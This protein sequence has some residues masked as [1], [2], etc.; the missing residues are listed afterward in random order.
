MR[1]E[2]INT[3]DIIYYKLRPSDRPINPDQE[4]K[5]LVKRKHRVEPDIWMLFVQ[6]LGEGYYED[7]TEWIYLAQVTRADKINREK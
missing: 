6:A 5:G 1:Q 2:E 3:G 4:Y 7:C